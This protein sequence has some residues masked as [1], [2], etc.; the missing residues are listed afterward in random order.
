MGSTV[1][2]V[3]HIQAVQQGWP[4]SDS[5]A[6][7]QRKTGRLQRRVFL[8][9][10]LISDA[11]VLAVALVLAWFF[12]IGSGLLPY[13]GSTSL[14]TYLQVSAASLVVFLLVFAANGLYDYNLLL[15]GPQEY[16]AIFRAC[17]YGM[18]ALVF[19]SF[20]QRNEELA[21]GWLLI[22][23]ALSVV[24]I[25]G[26]RFLWRRVFWWLRRTRQWLITPTL[27]VGANEQG[28]AIARQLVKRVTGIQVVGYLDDYLPVGS[29]VDDGLRVLGAPNQLNDLAERY[30]V[31]QVIV[32]SNGV[33]WETFTEI[34]RDAG[35]SDRFE[36][37]LSPGFYEILTTSVQVTH[38]GFVPLLRVQDS[39]ITGI[40]LIL[41][42]SLDYGL[43]LLFA[44]LSLP[45]QLAIA[46]AI[47][48]TGGRP[49][50]IG[51]EVLGIH[52]GKFRT[53]KFNSQL[54]GETGNRLLPWIIPDGLEFGSRLGRLLYVSGLDKLPQLIN[55]LRG[56]MSLVGPRTV[57]TS[58][59]PEHREWLPNLLTV[60]PGWTGPWAV[61]RADTFESEMQ[62]ALYY[63]RNW[64]V[65]MDLQILF[66][67]A[68]LSLFQRT[69]TYTD[70]RHSSE[71]SP[72]L[73]AEARPSPTPRS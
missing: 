63:I 29:P 32:V 12:R 31:D 7:T 51:H 40:D 42:S 58:L 46:L 54:N 30:A 61:H 50:L 59:Q 23:W 2:A 73:A 3:E 55:V 45:I 37:Q 15:G 66:R 39:R 1:S 65:W 71:P 69:G 13:S 47:L 70:S 11:L 34:I 62:L 60:K 33:T 6:K 41:K 26:T 72:N 44:L 24:L 25:G 38:R 28:K 56:Q 4:Q 48:V 68:R 36:L 64:T 52:G 20:M 27:I 16:G 21:R 8:A 67:T 14:T 57:S 5:R 43:G 19:V 17:S 53:L 10:L 49:I 22:T 35:Q 18:V 9:T